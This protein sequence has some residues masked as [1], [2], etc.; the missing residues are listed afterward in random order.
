MI[1]GWLVDKRTAVCAS[2]EL[3][4]QCEGRWTVLDDAPKCPRKLLLSYDEEVQARAW[5]QS[6]PRVSGCCDSVL[7]Y[8][9]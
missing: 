2:C 4:S 8:L 7:N 3:H 6:V 9:S 1:P 5:P